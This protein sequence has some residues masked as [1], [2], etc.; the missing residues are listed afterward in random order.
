MKIKILLFIFLSVMS[1]NPGEYP[2]IYYPYF[3]QGGQDV[4][5][6]EFLFKD[7]KGK[8]FVDIGAHDGISY[9][10]TF[11][12]EK[13]NGWRGICVEPT[14][15]NFIRLQQN[16]PDAICF[17]GCI[18]SKDDFV[19]FIRVEG[20]SEML[21]GI[22]YTYNDSHMARA[23]TEVKQLGGAINEIKVEAMT[24]NTL[25]KKNSISK[26][27]LLCV[28]TEGSEEE[29]IMNIDF[30]TLEIGVICVENNYNSNILRNFLDSK[31]FVFLCTISADDIFVNK[32]SNLSMELYKNITDKDIRKYTKVKQ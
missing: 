16:R 5:F 10:N 6:A 20:P 25:C 17:N 27:D 31:G 12:L 1:E 22:K 4:F 21:S 15:D 23:K 24:L 3:S 11:Y 28:D 29:I 18:F 19:D 2:Q 26:I 32:N 14:P 7:Q 13:N 30:N 9:S 8:T